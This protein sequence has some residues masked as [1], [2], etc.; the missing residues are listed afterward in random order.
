MLIWAFI[1]KAGQGPLTKLFD[2]C[3]IQLQKVVYPREEFLSAPSVSVHG[4]YP[5]GDRIAYLDS[6]ILKVVARE[7]SE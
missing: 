3:H 2:L 6:P 7:A 1:M 4:R 5:P